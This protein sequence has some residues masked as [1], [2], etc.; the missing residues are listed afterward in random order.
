MKIR[1]WICLLGISAALPFVGLACSKESTGD[2]VEPPKVSSPDEKLVTYT[3]TGMTCSGCE[4][5]IRDELGKLPNVTKVVASHTK[6]K[7]WMIVKGEAP[8]KE[9]VEKAIKAAGENYK[10]V[11]EG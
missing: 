9:A 11:G 7:A 2:V 5:H 6:E 8:S 10:L 1:S 3:V 4:G